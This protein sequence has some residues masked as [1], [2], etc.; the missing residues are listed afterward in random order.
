MIVYRTQLRPRCDSTSSC[1]RLKAECKKKEDHTSFTAV[2]LQA[3][4]VQVVQVAL[5]SQ[6]DEQY[7]ILHLAFVQDELAS[8]LIHNCA[9][10]MIM[11]YF[12]M[13]NSFVK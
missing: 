7:F 9:F 12:L 3:Q 4:V 2:Q 11:K 5:Q 6:C 13:T 8:P 1:T 10:Y